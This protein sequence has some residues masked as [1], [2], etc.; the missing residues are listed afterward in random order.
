MRAA[1]LE[2]SPKAELEALEKDLW[3]TQNREKN[4]DLFADELAELEDALLAAPLGSPVYQRFGDREVR[5]KVMP[6]TKHLVYYHLDGDV[7]RIVK[8]WGGPK[9][10]EPDLTDLL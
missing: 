10:E 4:P 7:V 5:R 9:G 2:Y 3:W 6:K 8:V 1:K